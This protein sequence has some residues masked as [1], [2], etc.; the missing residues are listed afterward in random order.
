MLAHL[1]FLASTP[2]RF[3]NCNRRYYKTRT[4]HPRD[5]SVFPAHHILPLSP[6]PDPRSVLSS[7]FSS[8]ELA[9]QPARVI[10]CAF[11][12]GWPPVVIPSGRHN[13]TL[14]AWNSLSPS[15]SAASVFIHTRVWWHSAGAARWEKKLASKMGEHG[16]GGGGNGNPR[17]LDW[18]RD[19]WSLQGALWM[20]LSEATLF[21]WVQ[22]DLT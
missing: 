15:S 13:A 18:K 6:S 12:L 7:H 17:S 3:C 11:A 14:Q 9:K 5:S 19:F 4:R 20:L 21:P 2:P 8:A 22:N 16:G 1:P 10:I